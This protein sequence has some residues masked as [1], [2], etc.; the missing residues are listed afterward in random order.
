MISDCEESHQDGASNKASLDQN[1]S[2]DVTMFNASREGE[3]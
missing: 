1:G 3:F 2:I